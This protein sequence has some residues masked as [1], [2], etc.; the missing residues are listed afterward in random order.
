MLLESSSNPATSLLPPQLHAPSRLPAGARLCSTSATL[1]DGFPRRPSRHPKPL[2]SPRNPLVLNPLKAIRIPTA[3][4]ARPSR[5]ARPTT[6]STEATLG[7]YLG[8]SRF[9]ARSGTAAFVGTGGQRLG[10]QA[11]RA[12]CRKAERQ[13]AKPNRRRTGRRLADP[14]DEVTMP[15]H[16]RR[17]RAASANPS[18]SSPPVAGSGTTSISRVGVPK[19]SPMLWAF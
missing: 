14:Q 17:R 12:G 15:A 9:L 18:S 10:S 13:N 5:R 4:S 8:G 11:P 6:D 19:A 2:H 3:T 7:C 1:P 16:A